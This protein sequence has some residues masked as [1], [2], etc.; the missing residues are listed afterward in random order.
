MT[1]PTSLNSI[2]MNPKNKYS[3]PKALDEIFLEETLGMKYQP[4]FHM[5]FLV[6]EPLDRSGP[7]ESENE[8]ADIW[9]GCFS[10]R[11]FPR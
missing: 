2:E 8:S 4:V 10:A 1:T 5:F 3:C 6:I 11:A 7:D 9:D